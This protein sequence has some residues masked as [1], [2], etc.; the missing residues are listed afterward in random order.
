MELSSLFS[1][2]GAISGTIF[3]AIAGGVAAEIRD[4]L[5]EKRSKKSYRQA[6]CHA[7]Y[8]QIKQD[9]HILKH[10]DSGN[11]LL[12]SLNTNLWLEKQLEISQ[13]IPNSIE[14][15]AEYYIQLNIFIGKLSI[16][17]INPINQRP[18]QMPIDNEQIEL[19]LSLGEQA[20]FSLKP[21]LS[22]F[23]KP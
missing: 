11:D 5:K 16:V 17:A 13:Y 23:L 22:K 20:L 8:Y 12:S 4:R 2:A 9:C 1:W 15:L 7:F 3:G 10:Y 18:I 21:F 6:L 14:A 19:M